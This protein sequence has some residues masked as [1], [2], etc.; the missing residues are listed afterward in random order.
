M[1]RLSISFGKIVILGVLTLAIGCA[2]SRPRASGS[3]AAGEDRT[4]VI[5]L[6]L[7]KSPS[8]LLLADNSVSCASFDEEGNQV[9]SESLEPIVSNGISTAE[10]RIN[11]KYLYSFESSGFGA[12]VPATGDTL[13]TNIQVPMT[14]GGKNVAEAIRSLPKEYRASFDLAAAELLLPAGSKFDNVGMKD[15][16][17][18]LAEQGKS[19]PEEKRIEL[20]LQR[21]KTP[22]DYIDI[23]KN[24]GN[25]EVAVAS[26]RAS[27]SRSFIVSNPDLA[28]NP[29]VKLSQRPA[30]AITSIPALLDKVPPELKTQVLSQAL[31][32]QIVSAIVA[33]NDGKA[34]SASELLTVTPALESIKTK[35]SAARALSDDFASKFIESVKSESFASDGRPKS[36]DT[37]SFSSIVME[38]VKKSETN[39]TVFEKFQN[40][41]DRY[42]SGTPGCVEWRNNCT[43]GG[44]VN[45]AEIAGEMQKGARA[46]I[47]QLAKLSNT[48]KA[49]LSCSAVATS[50][51]ISTA[52]ACADGA[53]LVNNLSEAYT[54]GAKAACAINSCLKSFIK[55]TT[56]EAMAA[57]CDAGDKLATAIKCSGFPAM[58]G[59]LGELCD[60]E[61]EASKPLILKECPY[62]PSAPACVSTGGPKTT[63]EIHTA[64]LNL[65]QAYKNEPEFSLFQGSCLAKCESLTAAAASNCKITSCPRGFELVNGSCVASAGRT[66]V[67]FEGCDYLFSNSL[68][69][70]SDLSF[71]GFPR[72]ERWRV[73]GSGWFGAGTA[74][75]MVRCEVAPPVGGLPELNLP[76]ITSDCVDRW[77]NTLF[78]KNQPRQ[79]YRYDFDSSISCP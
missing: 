10:V 41:L 62:T 67:V 38:A 21:A 9:S 55:N 75:G 16:I 42:N 8:N 11:P 74:I 70:D 25:I 4:Y 50:Q 40:N 12:V 44:L 56:T 78:S 72:S 54:E 31:T 69:P 52:N 15:L 3:S 76:A 68:N 23:V 13:A 46:V 79:I 17:I 63:D 37:A 18:A 59:G 64:C 49:I 66:T 19:L 28:D 30:D 24:S 43:A 36:F 39:G 1:I 61:I 20:N 45:P 60:T 53:C 7:P 73:S 51:A 47:D 71:Y 65:I 27:A 32:R 5:T 26:A 58:G 6:V 35:Y 33:N 22:I 14:L 29:I 57:A 2:K 48:D 34:F 77:G